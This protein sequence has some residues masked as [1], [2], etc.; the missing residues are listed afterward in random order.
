M[1]ILQI[2]NLAK[3]FDQHDVLKDVNFSVPEHSIY[4]FIGQ[5]G[6]GKT[7][8]MKIALG[9]L[10]AD[11]GTVM[12]C[13]ETVQFG[14]TKTNKSIGYLPDV[15]E[16]Y[17]YMRP[18]EY[19][20][21]CGEITGLSNTEIKSRSHELLD[22]VGLTNINKKIGGFSRG[23]KQRLGVA[24]ALINQPALLICDEPTSALDPMG[25]KE[26][27][28]ILTQI[29]SQTTIIFSTH[30][31]SDV[32]KICDR[33]ALLHDGIIVMDGTITELT[34]KHKVDCIRVEFNSATDKDHFCECAPAFL[35]KNMECFETTVTLHLTNI[36]T[37]EKELLR[38]FYEQSILPNHFELL[39]PTI[40]NLYL[41]AVQ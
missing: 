36:R 17:N 13:G 34:A 3:K 41:E 9:L 28:D 38:L 2:K 40:E 31:L 12:V 11:N 27:L 35:L 16:F 25:R 5:N 8:T 30:I 26:L 4:G 39:S 20:R 6:A 29:R 33:V 14:Q 23:M 22:L 24:Q 37:A 7:T 21:L 19:L 32:E 10:P 15:P 18:N 1:D